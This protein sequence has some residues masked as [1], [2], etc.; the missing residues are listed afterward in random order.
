MV[1]IRVFLA[2]SLC[3]VASSQSDVLAQTR[4]PSA[5]PRAHA[6]KPVP[7]EAAPTTPEPTSFMGV[8]FG[9]P[10]M[11]QF[12]DCTKPE[13]GESDFE[14][15]LSKRW[16]LEQKGITCFSRLELKSADPS[17]LGRR[18][19]DLNRWPD[20]GLRVLGVTVILAEAD[21]VEGVT[22][23]VYRYDWMKMLDLLTAKFGEPQ[24]HESASYANLVGGQREG[25]IYSWEWPSVTLR[26]SEYGSKVD[27][28][29]VVIETKRLGLWL[30]RQS[31]E[32]AQRNK[33]KL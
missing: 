21:S 3:L 8:K 6:T 33:D 17:R 16:D 23:T 27:E 28:S 14:K 22:V 32:N 12:E 7:S 30:K 13:I 20:L 10:V 29:S 1:A 18:F 25:D 5:T 19:A 15:K 2:L 4:K 24:K 9:V 26:L 11:A 31:L